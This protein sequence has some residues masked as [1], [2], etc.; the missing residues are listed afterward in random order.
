MQDSQH[1]SEQQGTGKTARPQIY[2]FPRPLFS[3]KQG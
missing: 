1:E 3:H 2:A